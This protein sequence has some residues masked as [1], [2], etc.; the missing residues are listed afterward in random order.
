VKNYLRGALGARGDGNGGQKTV[1]GG[2]EVR[3]GSVHL[4]A[5]ERGRKREEE[6]VTLV[7]FYHQSH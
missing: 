1:I 7:Q 5:H 6:E 2:G 4:Y 3:G